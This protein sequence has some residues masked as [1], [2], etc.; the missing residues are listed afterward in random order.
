MSSYIHDV[1]IQWNLRI[2]N[3]LG[4]GVSSFIEVSFIQRLKCTGIIGI[5]M[6]RFER[7]SLFEASFIRNS[8]VCARRVGK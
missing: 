7:C 3:T 4:Q 2:K 5:G 6:S 1:I 8:T